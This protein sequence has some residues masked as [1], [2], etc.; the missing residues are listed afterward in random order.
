MPFKHSYTVSE[1]SVAV[2]PTK[3]NVF[4]LGVDNPVDISKA[5]RV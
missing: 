2:S 5:C 3:M 4:Y 1:S